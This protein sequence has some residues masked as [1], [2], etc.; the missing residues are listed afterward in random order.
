MS[1]NSGK[2]WSVTLVALGIVFGDIGTS[3]L[4]A[5]RECFSG[6]HFLE[7][8]NVNVLGVLSLIFW[9]MAIIVS[10]KYI[11]VVTHADNKG[12][13]GVLPLLALS[14]L[15]P[16]FK[17]RK[18][19]PLFLVIGIFGAALLVGDG[20]IT[21]AISVLS[22]VEGLKIAIPAFESMIIPITLIILS[23]L[24]SIQSKGADKI[25]KIFGPVMLLWFFSLGALGLYSAVQTPEVLMS[26]LPTY[27]LTMFVEAPLLSFFILGSV[28]LVV[29]GCEALYAD[30]GH[31]GRDSIVR[32]WYAIVFP[33]LYLNYLGQGALLLRDPTK[34]SNPFY[35]LA[36]E[37][38]LI[39]LVILSTLATII[40]S[41]AL[42]SGMFSM[43]R[44]AIQL[45]YIPR[46]NIQQTSD[47]E[48]GQVYLAP[49][50]WMLFVGTIIMVLEFKTSSELAAAYG[51]AVSLT[52]LITTL[53]TVLVA[54]RIWKFSLLKISLVFGL[55]FIV[56]GAFTA[57]N[58]TKFFDGGYVPI[59]LAVF[60]SVVMFTWKKGRAVLMQRI[61]DSSYPFE[62]LVRDLEKATTVKVEG[63]AVFLVG[64]AKTTPP[65]LI[66]N[67]RHNKVLHKR[68]VFLT[69]QFSDNSRTP[70]DEIA[71]VIKL[72][73][74]FSQVIG[75]YGFK[76]TPNVMT[77]LE[78]AKKR[79]ASFV[80]DDPTF[81]LGREILVPAKS[82]DLSFWRKAIFIFLSKNAQSANS[83]FKL[84]TDRVI[85]VGMQVEL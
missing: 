43:A 30:M 41:Q 58:L 16:K 78:L 57:A 5:L 71:E 35:N 50:N 61:R 13:G 23:L 73:P 75:H 62:S 33:G 65:A 37:P 80:Y 26:I 63:T 46:I 60:V 36:P 68:V 31:F 70:I 3:P 39:P 53:L 66:H 84:P 56:E 64:D 48:I 28:F 52:M 42:I 59:L 12:E 20:I 4:Y 34:I 27:A 7:L 79:D 15:R 14:I 83:F 45:G 1:N 25:G 10:G 24:F 38:L 9:T 74:G 21:P 72:A 22:A 76:D 17:D 69:I 32:G 19:N 47:T 49:I 55:F 2:K 8:S 82:K 6:H 54:R 44:Q 40:A 11:A 85:E 67:L 18:F 29:T 77:L 51:I 81:F